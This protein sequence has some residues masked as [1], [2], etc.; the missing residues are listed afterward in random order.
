MS[1]ELLVTYHMYSNA[2]SI[3]ICTK[4]KRVRL[5]AF[6]KCITFSENKPNIFIL[7]HYLINKNHKYSLPVP[8]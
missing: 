5:T 6:L 2:N 1:I 7:T 3:S 4:A 8:F